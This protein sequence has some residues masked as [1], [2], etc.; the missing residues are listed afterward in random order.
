M[1]GSNSTVPTIVIPLFWSHPKQ[2]KGIDMDSH[3]QTLEE[4]IPPSDAAEALR[5]MPLEERLPRLKNVSEIDP[6][7]G[8]LP[9]HAKDILRGIGLR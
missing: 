9:E 2:S 4:L 6:N 1:V 8:D 5:R 3:Q 7:A